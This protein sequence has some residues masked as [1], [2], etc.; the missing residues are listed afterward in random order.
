MEIPLG[1]GN[2]IASL[3]PDAMWTI[4]NEDLSRIIWYSGVRPTDK[5]IEDELI[6]LQS[7]RDEQTIAIE[8]ARISG[9]KKLAKLGLTEDEVK[10]VIGL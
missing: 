1:Y 3:S 2:A 10:A 7:I 5:E 9:L 6:R 8:N 4:E